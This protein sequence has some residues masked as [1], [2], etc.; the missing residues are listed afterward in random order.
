MPIAVHRMRRLIAAGVCVVI[1]IACAF[2][3]VHGRQLQ[4]AGASAHVVADLPTPM[5]GNSRAES[6]DLQTLWRR[7]VLLANMLT[8]QPLLESVAHRAGVDPHQIG[9]TTL[10]TAN[11]P[12]VMTEPDSERRA[13]AIA[14]DTRPYRIEVQPSETL[15][16]FNVYTRAPSA[17][18]AERL[19]AGV[20]PTLNRYLRTMAVQRGQDPAK[21]VRLTTVGPVVGGVVGNG[22][23]MIAGL[24]FLLGLGLSSLALAVGRRLRRRAVGTSSPIAEDAAP[25]HR[26]TAQRPRLRGGLPVPTGMVAALATAGG[27][28]IALPQPRPLRARRAR[29]HGVLTASARF[30]RQ[31]GDWPRTTRLLPW[32]LAVMNALVWLVPFNSIQLQASLPIDLKLDR[33]VLPLIVGVWILAVAMGGRQAPRIR[34]TWIHVALAACLIIAGLSLIVEG[35]AITQALELQ[36]GVKK[37]TLLGA[38]ALLFVIVAST[39]RPSEVP[40]FLRYTLGLAVVCAVGTL[41]EYRFHYNVFYSLPQKLL[42]S[43]IFQVTNLAE[44]AAYDDIGRRLVRGPAEIPLESV[45]M[46][47]MA[48]PIALVGFIEATER[49]SRILNGLATV[50]LLAAM[51]ATFRKSAFM[52][53]VS[54]LLTLAYFRRRELLRLAPLALVLLVGIHVLSPGAFGSIAVQLRGSQALTVNTVSDRSSDYDAIRPDVWSHLA[55]GRG[56]GTYEHQSYRILDME[57]LQELVEVGVLGLI[58]Y[59]LTIVAVLWIA[60]EPI[61]ARRSRDGPVALAVAAAGV[62]FLVTSTLFDIMSFPH[63]PYIFLWLAGLLAVTVGPRARRH[64]GGAAWSS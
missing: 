10:V 54:V 26:P 62:A 42:P 61:R 36:T 19:A 47:V 4:V 34:V 27:G 15:P 44:S 16:A 7:A 46:I 51:M 11:V 37:L 40:A 35:H 2:A 55:L 53:P 41:V 39:I 50:L 12:T 28:T 6:A 64:V 48:L 45:A 63:C 43:S 8:S 1:A 24:G 38:Y 13:A 29:R 32:M 30:A 57:L 22:R 52:A 20:A 5:I 14:S 9:G 17:P 60:R 3:S 49:R 56:Y 25:E 59:V 31:A 18:E 23:S 33:L 21:L 58:A